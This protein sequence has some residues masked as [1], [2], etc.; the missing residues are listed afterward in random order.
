MFVVCSEKGVEGQT[1]S[2]DQIYGRDVAY[3]YLQPGSPNTS[4][5]FIP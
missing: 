4:R 5:E 1:V 3:E 2:I